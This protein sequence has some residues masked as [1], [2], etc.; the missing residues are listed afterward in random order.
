L[1]SCSSRRE[2]IR[3]CSVRILI[4]LP[5]TTAFGKSPT[6][7]GLCTMTWT[8]RRSGGTALKSTMVLADLVSA[9]LS[10]RHCF[11][12]GGRPRRSVRLL[13]QP[14]RQPVW[15]RAAGPGSGFAVTSL[16][17]IGRRD[18]VLLCVDRSS[19]GRS[20]S[21]WI[22]TA[23]RL[24]ARRSVSCIFVS[25]EFND[26]R[27]FPAQKFSSSRNGLRPIASW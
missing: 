10:L 11:S 14:D 20:T 27:V 15:R 13:V 16:L 24:T 23:F 2:R 8:R 19:A 4:T 7:S 6:S 1:W 12:Q 9:T 17:L 5:P 3:S 26:F 22:C 18:P 25:L 21:R